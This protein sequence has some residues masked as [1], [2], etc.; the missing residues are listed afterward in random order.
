MNYKSGDRVTTPTG[1]LVGTV[2]Y[3]PT[4]DSKSVSVKWD[5]PSVTFQE[6]VTR[7]VP[8]KEPKK[9]TGFLYKEGDR[10]R[11]K[12]DKKGGT[13]V[14][15]QIDGHQSVKVHW[16]ETG[17]RIYEPLTNLIALYT[18]RPTEGPHPMQAAIDNIEEERTKLKK[19]IEGLQFKLAGLTKAKKILKEGY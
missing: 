12:W 10:V 14:E 7:L 16:D 18:P 13:V 5:D 11:L 1:H 8:Y 4:P 3:T 6:P 2:L 19:Q 17:K 15:D 9:E